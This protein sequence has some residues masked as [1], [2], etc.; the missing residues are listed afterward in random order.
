MAAKPSIPVGPRIWDA[1]VEAHHRGVREAVLD[2]TASLVADHGILAVT[3]SRIAEETGIGRATLYRHF[4][5]VEAILTAWH[6]RHVAI[7][8]ERLAEIRQRADPA[9]GRLTAVLE[10]LAT[11]QHRRHAGALDVVLH[12][13][14]HVAQAHEH[15]HAVIRELIAEAAQAGDVRSDVA[16]AELASYC[17][18][19]LTA[20]RTLPSMVAVHRL[21][22]I[23]VG[24]LRPSSVPPHPDA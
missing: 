5:D 15:V 10:T 19:A 18:A 21:V 23:V 7:H 16:P 6:E 20:S 22:E 8:L 24:S 2:A 3:M 4:P 14:G 12:R 9:I 11:G 17:V 1:S 13:G